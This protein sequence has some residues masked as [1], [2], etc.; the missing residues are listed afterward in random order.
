MLKEVMKFERVLNQKKET[1]PPENILSLENLERIAL[2]EMK[3]GVVYITDIKKA[4][5]SQGF[6][7][8]QKS[9]DRQISN[10]KD[11]RRAWSFSTVLNNIKSLEKL[12]KRCYKLKVIKNG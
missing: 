4:V 11:G 8:Y 12:T 10:I 1:T 5:D 9:Q 7:H 2:K 6:T 3:D